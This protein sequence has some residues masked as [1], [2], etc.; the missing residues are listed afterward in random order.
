V[1]GARE[2][3]EFK[4]N[5]PAIW[6]VQRDQLL[7]HWRT[8]NV[9]VGVMSKILE[10]LTVPEVFDLGDG[11]TAV[12]RPITPEDAGALAR[13]HAHLSQRAVT[14]RYFYPHID[15]RT[16]EITHLTTVDGR[17]RVALVVE[18]GDELIAVGRFDRLDDPTQ[19]EV[20]FVVANAFQRHGIATM[21]FRQLAAI[22]RTVGITHF[23]AEV[24]SENTAMLSVFHAGGYPTVSKKEWGT[25]EL[26]MGIRVPSGAPRLQVRRD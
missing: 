14:M 18:K 5:G 19:A 26:Q 15:L 25:I 7:F 3:K 10:D 4:G 22:A 11:T 20:A 1:F 17:D 16:E 24:L 13:F 21:L 6:V 9:S 23:V 12:V 2:S 8:P